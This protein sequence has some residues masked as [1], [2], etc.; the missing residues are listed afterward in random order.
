MHLWPEAQGNANSPDKYFLA[1]GV[2]TAGFVRTI[3]GWRI[4]E[5]KNRVVWRAGAGFERMLETG[6][7]GG[8]RPSPHSG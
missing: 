2:I 8:T 5:L 1:G 4:S 6:Q 3:E 7:V